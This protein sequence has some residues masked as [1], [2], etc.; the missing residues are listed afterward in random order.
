MGKNLAMMEILTVVSK[1]ALAFDFEFHGDCNL[2]GHGF[3]DKYQYTFVL[4]L[5]ELLLEFRARDISG[6]N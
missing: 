2:D 5:P 3:D 6:S 4:T 1:I